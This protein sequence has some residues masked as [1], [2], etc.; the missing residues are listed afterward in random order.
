[1]RVK[2]RIEGIEEAL[3]ALC[4][5]AIDSARVA[6]ALHASR[7]AE[8][9][10]STHPYTDRT[11]DLTDSIEALDTNR[12]GDFV[13][14]YVVAGMGYASYVEEGTSR[15]RPYPY[16]RPAAERLDGA[17]SEAADAELE[18]AAERAGWS[19]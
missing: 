16:L 18:G 5:E 1:M 10:R 15:N 7:V 3:D 13:R 6:V 14:G 11:G 17:L 2:V 19:R 4:E 9:A 8:E 12:E